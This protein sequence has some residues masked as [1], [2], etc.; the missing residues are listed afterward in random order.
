MADSKAAATLEMHP[1]W[2]ALS[3]ELPA[4][5]AAGRQWGHVLGAQLGA[6]HIWVD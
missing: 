4:G 3:L 2:K 1:A 5:L 6:H